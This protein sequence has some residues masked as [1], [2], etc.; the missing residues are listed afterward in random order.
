MPASPP[1]GAGIALKAF[2]YRHALFVLIVCAACRLVSPPVVPIDPGVDFAAHVE[3]DRIVVDRL[4]DGNRGVV[5]APGWFRWGGAPTF[6]LTRDG[7]MVAGLWLTAP[8]TV[9]VRASRSRTEPVTATVEPSWDDNAI[10]LAMRPPDGPSLRT[11]TFQRTAVGGGPPVL[12]RNAQTS[13]DVRG[14][15]R[16]AV[17]DASGAEAGWLRVKISPYQESPRIYDGVLPR[18]FSPGVAAA[19]AVA[20]SS[21]IDWIE[22]HSIDVNRDKGTAGPLQ[23]SVPMGR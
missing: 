8:A 7:Q 20:L 1:G 22:S 4:P 3:H 19:L 23:Q 14:T 9:Q 13:I 10:R 5:E 11:D 2:M 12:T 17:R 16:A 18:D 21:E 15:Y 6:V